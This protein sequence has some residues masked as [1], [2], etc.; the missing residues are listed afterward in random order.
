ML[1]IVNESLNNPRNPVEEGFL[2]LEQKVLDINH[3]L[4]LLIETL[5]NKL[6]IFIEYGGFNAED[7]S[8]GGS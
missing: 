1:I 6:G 5:K 4:N 7:K 2:W 8:K 3:N